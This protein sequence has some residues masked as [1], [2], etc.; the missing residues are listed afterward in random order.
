MVLGAVFVGI[1]GRPGHR[2]STARALLLGILGTPFVLL[3]TVSATIG[4]VALF[5]WHD[6]GLP[7]TALLAVSL[8]ACALAMVGIVVY[9]RGRDA[10]S[11]ASAFFF[12]H[13]IAA[14]FQ[15]VVGALA[16]LLGDPKPG[17]GAQLTA[18]IPVFAGGWLLVWG[19]GSWTGT[20][21]RSVRGDR[22]GRA[23]LQVE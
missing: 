20:A 2:L 9:G 11:V 14:A 10:A 7:K 3:S 22:D 4:L 17:L 1:V 19:W 13:T 5:G 18:W 23:L 15:I 21:C 12:F 8:V 16:V 6:A